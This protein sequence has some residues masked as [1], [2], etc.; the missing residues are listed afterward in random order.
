MGST[1]QYNIIF[2][3]M[4]NP[5]YYNIFSFKHYITGEYVANIKDILT[6]P[7]NITIYR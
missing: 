6:P 7:Y 3:L 4:F 1:C 5:P 2:P